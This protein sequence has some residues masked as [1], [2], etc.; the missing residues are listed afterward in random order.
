[1]EEAG[2]PHRRGLGRRESIARAVRLIRWFLSAATTFLSGGGMN[3]LKA[4]V[5]RRFD[6]R[7]ATRGSAVLTEVCVEA[8]L[9]RCPMCKVLRAVESSFDGHKGLLAEQ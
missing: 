3:Q 4:G 8:D 6:P 2:P 5:V 9:S 7:S 1:L